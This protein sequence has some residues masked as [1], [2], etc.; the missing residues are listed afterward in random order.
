[1]RQL[2][3]IL[4]VGAIA[5]LLSA[6]VT[7]YTGW[8]EHQTESEAK[9]WGQEVAA[10]MGDPSVDGTFVPTVRY[11]C[12]GDGQDC[13]YNLTTYRNPVFGAFSRDGIVDRDGD[14]IQ[15]RAGSLAAAPADPQGQFQ[16]AY[17]WVDTDYSD[18]QFF[19]NLK[20]NFLKFDPAVAVCF[21]APVEE[22]DKDLD[23]QEEFG[24]LGDLFSQIWSGALNDSFT[25]E[26]TAVKLDGTS[27]PLENSVTIEASHNG[28]RPHSIAIDLTTPGG[29]ELIQAILDNTQHGV[30]VSVGASFAGGMQVDL[31]SITVFAFD[32]D[33]LSAAL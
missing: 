10:S 30:P 18:C 33:V 19:D 12:R 32:H 17:T 14:E 3:H 16:P 21:T 26:L 25:L 11:D 13:T 24:S 20:Q 7:D 5:A 2:M 23:L 31:P 28:I 22:I 1:M 9:L 27:I 29:Q 6:C 15:G 8:P 4:G